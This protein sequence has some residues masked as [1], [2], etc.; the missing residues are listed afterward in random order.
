MQNVRT[1]GDI[2]EVWS[3]RIA[4]GAL[5]FITAAAILYPMIVAYAT[6]CRQHYVVSAD[7][8]ALPATD[9][10]LENWLGIQ[11]GVRSASVHR[12]GQSVRHY[13]ILHRSFFASP[14]VPD[15][16]S[17]WKR[18]GYTEP[19]NVDWDWDDSKVARVRGPV[20]P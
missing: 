14:A 8:T 3:T 16:A 9:S 1:T 18:F 19:R 11:T 20:G 4:K 15:L 17:A 7:F 6:Y 5:L 13:W 2:I 12:D 10:D